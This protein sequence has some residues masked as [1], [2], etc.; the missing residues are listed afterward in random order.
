MKTKAK[1][2]R[3]IFAN[4][5]VAFFCLLHLIIW[6]II[7][8]LFSF[9]SWYAD[10]SY[11]FGRVA[12]ILVVAIGIAVFMGIVYLPVLFRKKTVYIGLTLAI[13]LDLA[14]FGG[15][16][17]F[18]GAASG[19]IAFSTEDW[20][21]YPGVR[22]TMFFNDLKDNYSIEGLSLNEVEKLLGEP[23]RISGSEYVYGDGYGNRLDVYFGEDNSADRWEFIFH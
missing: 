18:S 3:N 9:S 8:I 23:D 5:S 14:A 10:V 21:K 4:V 12:V 17:A 1:N 6:G 20:V 22:S 16:V 13:V 7:K 11:A 2:G 19:R 15:L